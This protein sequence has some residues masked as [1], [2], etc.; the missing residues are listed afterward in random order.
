MKRVSPFLLLA[1]LLLTACPWAQALVV[2]SGPVAQVSSI[3]LMRVPQ[4]LPYLARTPRIDGNLA[5]AQRGTLRLSINTSSDL[6]V[7][8][9]WQ[10]PSDAAMEVYSAWTQ[11]GL[12]LA[13]VVTDDEVISTVRDE[14]IWHQD[15][16]E[17]YLDTRLPQYFAKPSYT[18]GA[19]QLFIRPPVNGRGPVFITN[20]RDGRL[21]GVQIAGMRTTD[22]YVVEMLLP[23]TSLPF[24][25]MKHGSLIG[26][27]CAVND[28]DSRDG[29]RRQPRMLSYRG[30]SNL[31]ADP[32][33]CLS[34]ALV[35]TSQTDNIRPVDFVET[36]PSALPLPALNRHLRL[37]GE[38]S[39]WAEAAVIP[40]Q[41]T[42]DQAKVGKG[43]SLWRGPHDAGMTIYAAWTPEGLCLASTVSDDDVRNN[44]HFA[45]LWQ[46]D[47]IEIFVDGRGPDTLLRAPYTSGAYQFFVRPPQSKQHPMLLINPAQGYADNLRIAGKNTA[48]G[49]TVEMLIPWNVFP[50][51]TPGPGALLGLQFALNDYDQ[52]DGGL[53]QPRMLTMGGVSSLY[54]SPHLLTTFTLEGAARPVTAR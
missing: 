35:T 53:A 24:P 39:E 16:I 25:E 21:T 50:E 7:N 5:E 20:P 49:Y 28:Y 1:G 32:Q 12:Y 51:F 54:N 3:Q 2:E 52:R 47:S 37:D 38:L 42:Y 40:I 18:A 23:W 10:G 44:R 15:S 33:N 26:L 19:Y 4:Q 9:D 13:A 29:G 41:T 27:Q 46:Q 6:V 34:L 36:Q 11:K 8:H 45:N 31:F 43:A 30:V 48:T 22:G 14:E 17:I